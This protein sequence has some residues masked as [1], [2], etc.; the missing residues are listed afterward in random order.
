M[1]RIQDV[2][3]ATPMEGKLKGNLQKREI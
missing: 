1:Q 2:K 3:N